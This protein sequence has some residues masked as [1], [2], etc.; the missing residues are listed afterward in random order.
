MLSTAPRY[1]KNL[2]YQIM[3]SHIYIKR[4]K[5]KKNFEEVSQKFSGNIFSFLFFFDTRFTPLFYVF[6]F[7]ILF[8]VAGIK[9]RSIKFNAIKYWEQMHRMNAFVGVL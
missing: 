5:K 1:K 7:F 6:L 9:S 3:K 2:L 8:Y 4:I